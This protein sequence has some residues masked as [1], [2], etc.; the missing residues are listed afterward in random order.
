MSYSCGLSGI[1]PTDVAAVTGSDVMMGRTTPGDSES[2]EFGSG[3]QRV[4]MSVRPKHGRITVASW[5]EGR[6]PLRAATLAGVGDAAVW[7]TELH[8]L[9]AEQNDVLCDVSL[10]GAGQDTVQLPSAELARRAAILCNKVFA[11]TGEGAIQNHP[12]RRTK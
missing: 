1:G 3:A 7:Q 11:P 9:I 5:L 8:E 6:M 2:C 4:Q 10:G 12:S